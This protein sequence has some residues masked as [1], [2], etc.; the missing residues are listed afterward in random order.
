MSDLATA[1]KRAD[2]TFADH[3]LR[4]DPDVRE[5]LDT[6]LD[7]DELDQAAVVLHLARFA[8]ATL[9]LAYRSVNDLP[10]FEAG[11]GHARHLGGCEAEQD[12]EC[13]R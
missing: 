8:P 10:C 2:P 13:W 6:F 9:E 5:Q 4:Y 1:A 7:L 3:V 12:C 11:C